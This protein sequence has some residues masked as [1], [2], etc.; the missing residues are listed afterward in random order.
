[1]LFLRYSE[2]HNIYYQ[3]SVNDYVRS[4]S[5]SGDAS[6]QGTE[7]LDFYVYSISPEEELINREDYA[8]TSSAVVRALKITNHYIKAVFSPIEVEFIK[9]L[10]TTDKT[11]ARIAEALGENYYR[12]SK[13]IYSKFE[14]T[15]K[16]LLKQFYNSGYYCKTALEF[17]PKL[18]AYVKHNEQNRQWTANNVERRK[19]TKHK[20]YE[21]HYVRLTDEEII[22]RKKAKREAK[23]ATLPEDKREAQIKTWEY[24]DAY[25]LK[26]KQRSLG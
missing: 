4:H 14:A 3:K 23:L 2:L 6:S 9:G 15:K 24:Q 20:W 17:L 8:F 18:F 1:M 22:A 5:R 26:R 16:R 19:A 12:L 11:P 10:I 21:E 13:S 7:K 25:Y